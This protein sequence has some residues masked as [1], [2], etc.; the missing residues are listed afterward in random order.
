[1]KSNL[2]PK[3]VL[4][5]GTGSEQCSTIPAKTSCV[6]VPVPIFQH[7]TQVFTARDASPNSS[8][9]TDPRVFAAVE[10]YLRQC[11]AGPPPDID[12]FVAAHP[13]IADELRACLA[14]LAFLRKAAPNIE[15]S[16]AAIT[17]SAT[18]E[19]EPLG[20]YRLIREIGRGGMGIVYEAE[21]LSLS[22]RV[23]LKILP[24]AAVLDPRHLQRFKNEALAAA[25]LSHPHIVDV[26]GIGCE[27]SIHFYAMRLIEGQTL[28]AVIDGLRLAD[29]GTASRGRVSP[30]RDPESAAAPGATAGLPSSAE[31]NPEPRT[32]N[33]MADTSAIAALSTLRTTKPRD[34]FRRV[35][36]LGIQ[37]AE[38]LDHAHQMGIV[39]R[40][41]KPS[42]L[43][44]DHFGKLWIT[45]FGLAR[46]QN[47]PG[48]T[49]TGDLL[50]TL[51]YMS[52]EQAEGKSA[53]LDHRTDIY[54]LGITLYELLTLQPAFPATDRQ[55]LL[56]QI[57]FEEP[58]ALRRL[59]PTI[60]VELETIVTKAM[61]KSPSERY[62]TAADL[63]ADLQRFVENKPIKAKTPTLWQRSRKW[64]WRQRTILISTV[65]VL[66]ILMLAALVATGI[67]LR[68]RHK[69][70]IA[71][72]ANGPVVFDSLENLNT[73]LSAVDSMYTNLA[74]NWLADETAPTEMQREFLQQAVS[75]YNQIAL[76]APFT[77]S[78][79][80]V[81]AG[82]YE[83]IAHI[84]RYLGD[85]RLAVEALKK[86]VNISEDRAVS[87]PAQRNALPQRYRK[88]AEALLETADI[89]A[90]EEAI[91]DGMVH[92][93]ALLGD[94][95][96]SAELLVEQILYDQARAALGIRMDQLDLAEA[97]GQLAAGHIQTIEQQFG[98]TP[99]LSVP[100]NDLLLARIAYR[101]GDY[102]AAR[103]QAQSAFDD[104]RSSRLQEYRDARHFVE[105]EI[106][107]LE[108]LGEI[109]ESDGALAAAAEH[110]RDALDLGRSLLKAGREPAD[111]IVQTSIPFQ[112]DYQDGQFEHGPFCRYLE[113]QLRLARVFQLLGR[114][115]KAEQLLGDCTHTAAAICSRRQSVVRYHIA[116]ANAWAMAA[117]L[118]A[119][120][121]PLEAE[122]ARNHAMQIWQQTVLR[123]PH[124]PE[125]RSGVHG[126][127]NDYMW[128]RGVL[129]VEM[130]RTLSSRSPR[131]IA[132]LELPEIPFVKNRDDRLAK[133]ADLSAESRRVD[134]S[135][136]WLYQAL[137]HASLGDEVEARRWLE[138]ASVTLKSIETPPAGLTELR[139]Q[140]EK[141]VMPGAPKLSRPDREGLE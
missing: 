124:S 86:S 113:T 6:S 43:M 46:F 29:A 134:Q 21:Q 139:D 108:L 16:S 102:T 31:L 126:P 135:R 42:N 119:D 82:V 15:F 97:A 100:R 5:N 129:P 23:A 30:R 87:A 19:H 48:M 104:C 53:V 78:Q 55:A 74:I 58:T 115:E 47:E 9:T 39:H 89:P 88:L 10:N 28:A 79:H 76:R 128:F 95:P 83:R 84:Q 136:A 94:A 1:M 63:A 116:H 120:I 121:R 41:I 26:Y 105:M 38:A 54:S 127:V 137:S 69:T 92:L 22:R 103:K 91:R 33:P 61:A 111:F 99:L 85:S 73:A 45:D 60:P 98:N 71:L 122:P 14:G 62:S 81:T 112:Q 106:D 68:E 49:M 118:L 4:K 11:E 20:D 59:K 72:E 52:P 114:M 131:V 17:A 2:P 8:G 7:E 37:A 125:Y 109:S 90:A 65:C 64:A 77:E 36:E 27:R 133:L 51:R 66:F 12:E 32:L 34:Y 3:N 24:F 44:I 141:M 40:D 138:K 13:D 80:Y 96:K 110:Y 67:A 130:T 57:A 93:N 35:A 50:G 117:E 56:R 101:K 75:L 25:H 132:R 123:F 140:A 18:M 70:E 107:A